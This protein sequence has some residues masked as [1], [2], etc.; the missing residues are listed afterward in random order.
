[1]VAWIGT[2][3]AEQVMIGAAALSGAVVLWPHARPRIRP[4]IAAASIAI[5]ALAALVPPVPGLLVAYGR[6]AAAWAGQNPN[7]IYVGEGLHASI[8]V[9]RVSDGVLNYHNAGK[10]Q[11]SSEPSDM[12][13]QRMLGHLTT[14]V[15]QQARSVLV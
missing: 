15:P 6:H 3:H 14:L 2:G 12:R 7:I 10:T 1:L 5:G 11:A 13:L 9:S 4:L 8:A